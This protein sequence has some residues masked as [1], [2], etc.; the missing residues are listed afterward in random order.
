M[1]HMKGTPQTMKSKDQYVNLLQ[2]V[3]LYF[4]KK[5]AEARQYGINDI[6]ID[7]GFGFA[8]NTAQNFKL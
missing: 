1:M 5:T 4:A 2:D 6:I 3:N 7:P 8:K